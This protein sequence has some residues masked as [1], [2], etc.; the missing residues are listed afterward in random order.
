MTAK[1]KRRE[2][3]S[4]TGGAAAAWPI[5]ARGQQQER[6]R[7]IG[8]LMNLAADAQQRGPSARSQK[9]SQLT[10]STLASLS[11]AG[12]SVQNASTAACHLDHRQ[13]QCS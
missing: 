6:M 12:F 2:F 5:G 11:A 8:V 13:K 10:L 9:L 7:R 4:L 3:I 1:M